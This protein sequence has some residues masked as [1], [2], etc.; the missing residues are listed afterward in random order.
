MSTAADNPV[1]HILALSGGKAASCVRALDMLG[2]ILTRHYPIPVVSGSMWR[3][4]P[5]LTM[6]CAELKAAQWNNAL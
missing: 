2:P 5:M 3:C 6:N 4:R 1:R